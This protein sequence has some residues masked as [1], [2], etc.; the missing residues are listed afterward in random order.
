MTNERLSA[1][2]ALV[3]DVCGLTAESHRGLRSGIGAAFN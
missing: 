1:I 3:F 2:R